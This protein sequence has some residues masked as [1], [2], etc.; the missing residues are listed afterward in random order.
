LATKNTSG[1][2]YWQY[3]P[4]YETL[5]PT[6]QNW[7][8][9]VDYDKDGRKDLFTHSSAGL[10][11]YRNTTTADKVSWQLIA[12]PLYSIGFSGKINLN[13]TATDI[14]AITDIDNDG[15]IDVLLFDPSGDF[16]EFHRNNAVEKYNDPTRLEFVK[17][18]YCWGIL[19]SNYVKIFSLG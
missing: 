3:A 1:V 17:I 12:S 15:D 5:F 6:L 8:L 10:K 19:S 16:V 4:Q 13:V 18:G 2:Y 14:P 9:L 7:M 11:L